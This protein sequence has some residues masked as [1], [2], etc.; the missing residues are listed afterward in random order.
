MQMYSVTTLIVKQVRKD[1]QYTF[2]YN[3]GSIVEGNSV[4]IYRVGSRIL[5]RGAHYHNSVHSHCMSV[6]WWY[7]NI[8]LA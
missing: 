8:F 1:I 7:L 6:G 4:Y 3:V 2:I 5:P